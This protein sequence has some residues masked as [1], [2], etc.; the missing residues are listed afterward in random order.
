MKSRNVIKVMLF[1]LIILI[2]HIAYQEVNLKKQD[3]DWLD[4]L[5]VSANTDQLIIVAVT[6]TEAVLSFY[7][8]DGRREWTEILSVPAVIGKNGLGKTKEGDMK[9]P[10]GRFYF[11]KAFGILE[12]PGAKIDYIQVDEN[13]FWV[14]DIHSNYYNQFVTTK[15]VEPDW[16]T[17]EHICEYEEL[18]DYVLATS[19]NKEGIPGLGSAVFLHCTSEETEYTA[20]C[21]AIPKDCMHEIMKKVEEDCVLIIDTAE[22]L[23]I[24]EADYC[25]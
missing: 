14:D 22:R 23:N 18:Y 16:N 24:Y 13:H 9:T 25:R 11:T 8:K 17:A 15:E 20:G 3:A 1:I 12:N 21:V 10:I 4:E 19:Y 5:D 2:V 7:E 6:E